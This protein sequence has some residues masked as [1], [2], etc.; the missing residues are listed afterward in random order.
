MATYS[1][2]PTIFRKICQVCFQNQV[3]QTEFVSF[4]LISCIYKKKTI[5][6][7]NSVKLATL[8]LKYYKNFGFW[9]LTSKSLQL[10]VDEG[11]DLKFQCEW[12][13]FCS[14]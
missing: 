3:K 6:L 4:L 12:K 8:N 14:T 11:A 9:G 7:R 10:L 13:N 2:L 1:V 5:E